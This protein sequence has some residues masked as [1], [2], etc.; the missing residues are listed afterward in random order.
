[1]KQSVFTPDE[2]KKLKLCK[3]TKRRRIENEI[4]LQV[5]DY[6]KKKYPNIIFMCDLASGMN[7]GKFIGGMNRRLRSSRGLPDLFIACPKVPYFGLFIELKTESCRLK[8]GGIKKTEHHQEQAAI[9]TRLQYHGYKASFACGLQ[10]AIALIDRY[11]NF[12]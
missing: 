5:C 11:F 10:E 9:L 3:E 8:N 7:L 2:F 4:Q 1:M 6:L 12:S